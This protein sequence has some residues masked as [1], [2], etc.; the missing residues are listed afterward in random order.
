MVK[1][2]A[3][4]SDAARLEALGATEA[5][6]QFRGHTI[7]VPLNLEVWPLSL[8][9]ERPFDAVDYLLNGQGCG[10]GDNAT[11]DDYREL[12]DAMAE[13]VGVLR[14]PETPA[15]PDQWFGGIPTLVN[16]LD[17][18]EDDLVSDLRRFWGVDYAERFRGTLSLRQIWTYIRRLDP[19]SAIVRAQNGGKEF[20]TEQ[21][22]ILASVYQ[23]LTGEI[24]PG[25]PL[26]QHEIAKA[27]EAMQA[28][29]D[30]VANLKAREAAY[31][32]KSSPTAP[33]VS[34]M[35]Q[36]IANRRHELGKR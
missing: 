19:K 32:A 36:A 16:I 28:K 29:V 26:R 18:Y 5:E 2:A 15:A 11:V 9:R 14:L 13:A 8:V 21:M 22:F 35:E 24:Y 4:T 23:A 6:A 3:K 7:R 30:H 27:L 34:A 31:A 33:A 17:H 12:S 10:L 25:R 20:W 1:V